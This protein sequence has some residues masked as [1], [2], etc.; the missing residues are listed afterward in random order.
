MRFC[1]K[2]GAD[3][4]CAHIRSMKPH[5]LPVVIQDLEFILITRMSTNWDISAGAIPDPIAQAAA[6][7][8]SLATAATS[9]D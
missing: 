9:G 2:L 1:L 4:G 3:R 5:N 6:R 7:D 8:P